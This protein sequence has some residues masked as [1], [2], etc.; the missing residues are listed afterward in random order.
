[1][2]LSREKAKLIERLRNPRFRSREGSFLVEGVRAAKEFLEGGSL[3]KPRFAVLSP[4]LSNAESG[5]R[6]ERALRASGIPLEEVSDEELARLSDTEQTQGIL[7]VVVEPLTSLATLEV[8]GESKV[9][10][11][12]GIQD[13]GN[14]GT[15]FRVAWAFGL[16]AVIC[17][18]GSVDPFSSKV[19]RASAGAVAHLPVLKAPWGEVEGWLLEKGLPLLLADS[20]GSNVR[21]FFA[22]GGWVLAVGNEGAGPREALKKLARKT[23]SVPMAS[24]VDSLNAGLAGAILLFSLV[25]NSGTG[26]EN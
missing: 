26:M 8:D 1:M 22:S 16:Q 24:G 7:M 18:D 3:A 9:L 13:P 17:L 14:A 5:L 12:D 19:V 23:L 21:G 4:R 6:L 11:L 25:G 20:G 10:M 15:L 2:A